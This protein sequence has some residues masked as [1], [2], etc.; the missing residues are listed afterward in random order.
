MLSTASGAPVAQGALGARILPE[1]LERL[2]QNGIKSSKV[3]GFE[4]AD[5]ECHTFKWL[6]GTS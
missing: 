5:Q 6:R 1:N 4:V 3:T 2:R